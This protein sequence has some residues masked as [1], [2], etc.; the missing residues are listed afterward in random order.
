MPILSDDAGQT[1]RPDHIP[2][3]LKD[4]RQWVVFQ[5][6]ARDGKTTK[7]PYSARNG[8]KA[9]ATDPATWSTFT[10][11]LEAFHN[12]RGDGIGYVFSL[13]DDCFGIDLDKCRDPE[14]G[15]LHRDAQAIIARFPTYAEIS[16]SGKGVHIIGCGTLPAGGNR[17]GPIEMYDRG[18]YFTMT[19]NVLPDHDQLTDCQTILDSWHAEMFPA[20]APHHPK[21]PQDTAHRLDDDAILEKAKGAANGAKFAALMD[22]DTSGHGGDDSAADLALVSMLTFWTQDATQID[23]LFRRS[24]LCREKWEREDY[25][26]RTIGLALERGDFYD[27]AYQRLGTRL[28]VK[29]EGNQMGGDDPDDDPAWETPEPLDPMT[30]PPLPVDALPG[31][32]KALVLA[33]SDEL[34]APPDLAYGVAMGA[35][36]VSAAGKWNVYYEP[37]NWREPV[38]TMTISTAEPGSNKTAVFK[39]VFEPV[40]TWETEQQAR[41][42][43]LIEEWESKERALV[44]QLQSAERSADKPPKDGKRA[45]SELSRRAALDALTTH[46]EARVIETDL[47]S[48]DATPESVK[49]HMAEQGGAYGA[50]SAESAFLSISAGRY[51]TG[52]PNL[53]PILN[54]H[55]GDQI[56]I[57][58]TGQRTKVIEHAHLTLCLMLQPSVVHDLGRVPGVVERGVAARLLPV[59]PEDTVGHRNTDR[60]PSVPEHVTAGWNCGI[61]RILNTPRNSLPTD[62]RLSDEAETMFT[63]YR[64]WLEPAYP[65]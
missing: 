44:A 32:I 59:I 64:R 6:E 31:I 14:S 53:D 17:K 26:A 9:S 21:P 4:R 58:R 11:A 16:V 50:C 15:D 19:G 20:K 43:P 22:G 27:P 54:G 8:K 51:G 12:G 10:E 56:K 48:D 63:A 40:R 39:Q 25:R 49:Q 1:L 33:V 42:A 60:R 61:R 38:H 7:V 46:R 3:G 37:T 45:D 36:F 52:K 23:R 57:S 62:L 47:Y 2:S 29:L 5:F 13:D 65:G 55:N 34:Q 35:I 24:G 18:R 28:P 30:G 41:Q